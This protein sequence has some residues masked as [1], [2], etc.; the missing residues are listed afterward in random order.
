MEIF[1]TVGRGVEGVRMQSDFETRSLCPHLNGQ[2]HFTINLVAS[3][4]YLLNT[5]SMLALSMVLGYNN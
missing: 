3:P 4:I 1:E 2:R 5:S